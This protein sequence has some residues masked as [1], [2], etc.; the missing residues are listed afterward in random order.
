MKTLIIMGA[1]MA[2][3]VASAN[4]TTDMSCSDARQLVKSHGAVVLYESAHIY[5]RYVAHAGYCMQGET[6][7]PAWIHT[8]D[9]DQ[10][11]VGYTCETRS[12]EN[13]G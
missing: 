11:F 1:L 10:C 6:T 2:A 5:D 9:D 7:K 8:A 13:G 12:S 4:Y 3:S